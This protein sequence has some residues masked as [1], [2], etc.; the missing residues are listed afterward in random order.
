M[1]FVRVPV[2]WEVGRFLMF[3]QALGGF[4]LA[5]EVVL[6]ARGRINPPAVALG[7]T[8][9]YLVVVALAMVA[10]APERSAARGAVL[11]RSWY[12]RVAVL[13][14]VGAAICLWLCGGLALR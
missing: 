12:V 9:V 8:F 13:A 3:W 10:F 2:C 5:V 4:A 1:F 7:A 14:G 11:P 6:A